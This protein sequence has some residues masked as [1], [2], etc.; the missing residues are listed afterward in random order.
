M[1]LALG[2]CVHTGWAAAVVAGGDWAKPVVVLRQR[3]ELLGNDERF[4]FHK[5]AEMTTRAAGPWVSNAKN[6][7]LA[8]ATAVMKQLAATHGVKACAVVAKKGAMPPL[9]EV[10]A[11]HPR[12]HAAEGCSYRDALVEAAESSG[13]QA[14]VIAPKE[15]DPKDERLVEVGKVVGKPWSVHWKLAV[16]AAWRVA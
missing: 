14:R 15:L 10:V 4:V 2:L 13:M 16:L 12:I 6:E 8:R 3:V 1:R 11:A 5:A 9:E 7:A